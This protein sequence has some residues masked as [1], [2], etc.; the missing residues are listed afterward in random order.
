MR[1]QGLLGAFLLAIGMAGTVHAASRDV[2]L[3]RLSR[4]LDQLRADTRLGTFASSEIA[5]AQAALD[6]LKENGRG[7][8]REHVLYMA[9]R[10]VDIAWAAAQLQDH[11]RQKATLEDERSRLQLAVARH[12]AEQARRELDQQRLL[13]QI[14]AE[15]AEREVARV[16]AERLLTEQDAA[17]AREMA[18]Q[19][20][21]LAEAQSRETALARQEAEL[22]AAA[23]DALRARLNSLKATRG[24][25]GMEMT[26]EGIAFAPGQSGLRPEAADSIAK[27][28]EFVDSAPGKHVRIEGHTDSTGSDNANLVLSQQRAEAVRDALVAAGVE[29]GRMTAIGLGEA[30]P[31]APND[32]EAGR[33][34]NRRVVVILEEKQ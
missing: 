8:K 13:A 7:R 33:T 3:E 1:W 28:A 20:K 4:S 19:A 9:E 30:S 15:E 10:R 23:A 24:E 22:A 34:K 27:L 11:Q 18:E 26:L 21:R 32:T 25:R 6:A 14:R 5:R 16:E 29:A 2:D 12:Q 17:S 31:I